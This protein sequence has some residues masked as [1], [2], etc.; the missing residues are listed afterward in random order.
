MQS[1]PSG[2]LEQVVIDE[3]IRRDTI[4]FHLLACAQALY[5]LSFF[6]E[7]GYGDLEPRKQA[8]MMSAL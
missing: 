5:E 6:C 1:I 7:L 4:F 2:S 3:K 8:D